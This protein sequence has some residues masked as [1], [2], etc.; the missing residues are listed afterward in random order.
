M[1]DSKTKCNHVHFFFS[2]PSSSRPGTSSTTRT[3]SAS[4]SPLI[5]HDLEPVVLTDDTRLVERETERCTN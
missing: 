1:D 2:K 5:T 3:R 4:P